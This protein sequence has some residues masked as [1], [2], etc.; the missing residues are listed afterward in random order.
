MADKLQSLL[1]LG[2]DA[3]ELE[4]Q[5]RMPAAYLVDMRKIYA[6]D[7]PETDRQRSFA[8]LMNDDFHR[9]I[10]QFRAMEKEW[11]EQIAALDAPGRQGKCPDAGILDGRLEDEA[12]YQACEEWLKRNT[13]E[14]EKRTREEAAARQRAI[15]TCPACGVQFGD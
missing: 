13:E 10:T 15:G 6:G 8:K 9:F 7:R 3:A 1:T 2:I 14:T 11:R 12:A 5:A 4:A